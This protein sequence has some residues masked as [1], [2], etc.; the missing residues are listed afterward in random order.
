M[1]HPT[2]NE[3]YASGELPWGTGEPEPLLVEFVDSGGVTPGRT[4]EIGA[5]TGTNAIWLAERGFDVLGVDISPLA[6]E[7]AKAK[8][9]GRD[10]RCRFATLDILAAPAP[11]G[12]FR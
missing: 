6:V 7:Q 4:F 8:I 3:H 12:P 10:L 9:A 2:W 11:D 5:G 1:P